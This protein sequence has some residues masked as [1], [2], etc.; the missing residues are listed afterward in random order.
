MPRRNCARG[1]EPIDSIRT[2]RMSIPTEK[3]LPI[4]VSPPRGH[5]VKAE[6]SSVETAASG[7][8]A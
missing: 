1:L 4:I 8:M 3:R 2:D 5:K 6:S 7:S